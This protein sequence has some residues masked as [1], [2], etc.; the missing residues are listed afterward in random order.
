[1]AFIPLEDDEKNYGKAA[2]DGVIS[3]V[4]KSG[5]SLVYQGLLIIFSSVAASLNAITI[6]LLLAL[7]S[8]IFVIAWLGREYT[9]KTETL[10]RVNASEE[11]VLQEEREASSLVDAESREEPATTL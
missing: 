6:V 4:G 10:V 2:I 3:R 9:A 8:W 7:G 1:M 11:D 5:G